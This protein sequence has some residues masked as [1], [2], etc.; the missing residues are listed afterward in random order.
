MPKVVKDIYI[1][2]DWK[3]ERE[4]LK[5]FNVAL[6]PSSSNPKYDSTV[7]EKTEAEMTDLLESGVT[8]YEHI[9]RG[10][11][12]N[13]FEEYTAWVQALSEND[14]SDWIS[15]TNLVVEDDG[16]STIATTDANNNPINAGLGN[17][18][19]DSE[20]IKI[21]D[22]KFSI[23]GKEGNILI[24]DNKIELKGE[25]PKIKVEA[26][27]GDYSELKEGKI[28]FYKG[29]DKG[30]PHWY[31]KNVAYGTAE[32]GDYI[33]L[34]WDRRPKVIT[35]I[36]ELR[37]YTPGH[38]DRNQ[39]YTS[40]VSGVTKDGFYVYG[41]SLIVGEENKVTKNITLAAESI[42]TPAVRRP[43]YYEPASWS[44]DSESFISDPAK[45]VSGTTHLSINFTITY[46]ESYGD[47]RGV[48]VYYK[49]IDSLSW[50]EYS[51]FRDPSTQDVNL[52]IPN[53][54]PDKYQI[55]LLAYCEAGSNGDSKITVD[56][57]EWIYRANDIPIDN[58]KVM[59][60][61]IEG[62]LN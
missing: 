19:I 53:L 36:R 10:I 14:D 51:H 27:N 34:D 46:S 38:I 30:N 62:G 47:N 55:R 3:G 13:K 54:P 41:K 31:S 33:N 24:E 26:P 8:K 5:G 18:V 42:Y 32:D 7:M 39:A 49:T 23:K 59:W 4:L 21:T 2:W 28:A 25:E 56:I 58:G 52:E 17:L 45:S 61:A 16:V 35:A 9:F 22:G 50:I 37:S 12:L 43:H 6:T 60:I 11:I 57:H 48:R 20:G 40:Y 15:A 44:S 1:S 29:D